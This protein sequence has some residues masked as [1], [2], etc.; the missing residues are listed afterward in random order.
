MYSCSRQT[1]FKNGDLIGVQGTFFPTGTRATFRCA[2][3]Y[4][5]SG[6]GGGGQKEAEFLCAQE[7]G[8]I[9]WKHAEAGQEQVQGCRKG[10]DKLSGSIPLTQDLAFPNYILTM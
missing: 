6:A 4:V 1:N 2:R 7:G 5:I 8:A 9:L 10:E 3:G